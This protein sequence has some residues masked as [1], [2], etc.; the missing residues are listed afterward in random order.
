MSEPIYRAANG[1]GPDVIAEALVT[2]VPFSA[3]YDL[4]WS[5]GTFSR[6]GHDLFGRPVAGRIL[7]SPG[8][9]GGV[10]G[11]WV[12]LSMARAGIGLAGFVFIDVNP[13]IAQG[14]LIAGLSLIAGV[15]P[16]VLTSIKSGDLVRLN[17]RSKTVA[18]MSRAQEGELRG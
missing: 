12:L 14:A 7:I 13:V 11:G 16:T 15:D 1:L 6:R 4:D 8:V 17:P 2:S 3:R 18:V 5:A 9:Q 10:A